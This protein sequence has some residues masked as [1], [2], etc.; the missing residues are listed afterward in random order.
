MADVQDSIAELAYYR[1]HL[2]EYNADAAFKDAAFG[3]TFGYSITDNWLLNFG[4]TYKRLFG[5]AKDSISE[6]V[7]ELKALQS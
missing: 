6:V 3:A 1:E 7:S 5:D 4:G 2:D